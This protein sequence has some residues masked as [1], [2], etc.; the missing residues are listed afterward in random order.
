MRLRGIKLGMVQDG[1]QVAKE[2]IELSKELK[3][4]KL[5]VQVTMRRIDGLEKDGIANYRALLNIVNRIKDV[6]KQMGIETKIPQLDEMEKALN[7][8][9]E[10]HTI[11]I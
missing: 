7:I 8:W 9:S 5:D 11:R 10:A 6:N 2:L 4:N 3:G 1:Q